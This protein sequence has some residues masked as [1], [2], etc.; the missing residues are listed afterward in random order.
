MFTVKVTASCVNYNMYTN[1]IN[2]ACKAGLSKINQLVNDHNVLEKDLHG[3][4]ILNANLHVSRQGELTLNR[5]DTSWLRITNQ[6]SHGYVPNF[7]LISGKAGID[8]VK[9]TSWDPISNDVIRQNA[10]GSSPRPYILINSGTTN[11]SNSELR[12]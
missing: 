4:W 1:T 6:K 5:T 11:I 10:G 3:I 8:G 7:I 2:I 9:I 12:F